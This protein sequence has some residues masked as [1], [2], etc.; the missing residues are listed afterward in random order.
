MAIDLSAIRAI[1]MHVHAAVPCHDLE[2]P[3]MGQFFDAASAY[4]KAPRERPK[5]P[6]IA[7]I[8]REQQIAFC[9]FTVDCESGIGARRVS[10]Y[11]FAEFAAMHDDICI[12]FASIDPHKGKLGARE[13]RDLV[14]N[15]G[16]HGFKFHHIMQGI[17][18]GDRVAWPIYEVIAGH[19][20]GQC[21]KAAWPGLKANAT[22]N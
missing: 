17:D 2:D 8:S 16:V 3:V 4:F 5:M 15:C 20:E 11:E 1:D 21:R 22:A 18:P 10:N 6:E 13:A 19:R 12:P 7:Q 9:P 14:E